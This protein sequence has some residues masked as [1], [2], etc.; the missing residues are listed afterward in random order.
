MDSSLSQLDPLQRDVLREFFARERSFFL[1][2]GA[3]LAG[4]YLG[5]RKTEDLDLFS[6]PGTDLAV[7]D[8]ALAAAALACGAT[9]RAQNAS[10]DF[11]RWLVSRG[12]ESTLVDLVIDRAPMIETTKAVFDGVRVDSL[13]E[14][15]ANKICTLVGRTETKDLRDLRLL[16][17]LPG[18]GLTQALDDAAIKE[19]GADPATVAWV[20]ETF[21]A[22]QL[23]PADLRAFRMEL[24]RRL[25]AIEFARARGQ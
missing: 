18:I 22:T 11:H 23:E 20:L 3:A 6:A 16:L 17:E 5:H 2:G 19:G 7:G 14:I 10:P 9:V 15:A 1:T 12:D 8:R 4:F 24:A 13:R 25:R 21:P